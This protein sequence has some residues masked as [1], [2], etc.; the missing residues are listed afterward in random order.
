MRLRESAEITMEC[1]KV[2]LLRPGPTQTSSGAGL[3]GQEAL[4]K[5]RCWMLVYLFAETHLQVYFSQEQGFLLMSCLSFLKWF[6]SGKLKKPA[7]PLCRASKP[8]AS[9]MQK[10][11]RESLIKVVCNT[12]TIQDGG[13]CWIPPFSVWN[14]IFV[15]I[16][17]W[18][19]FGS[20]IFFFRSFSP[21]LLEEV[22]FLGP[23]W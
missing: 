4:L 23:Q 19:W 14:S 20:W 9:W 5:L 15:A 2:S 8:G 12:G 7:G 22:G 11:I 6:W 1:A 18:C 13:I 21:G 10:V 3:S 17:G 16:G